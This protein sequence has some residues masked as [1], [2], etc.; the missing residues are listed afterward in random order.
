MLSNNRGKFANVPHGTTVA[1][2]C[3]YV[4]LLFRAIID[5][6]TIRSKTLQTYSCTYVLYIVQLYNCTTLL[7]IEYICTVG[8]VSTRFEIYA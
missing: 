5:V 1:K 4:P 7:N 8:Q 3:Y 2:L 6:Q